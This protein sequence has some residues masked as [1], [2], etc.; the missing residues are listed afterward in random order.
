MTWDAV[1][2]QRSAERIRADVAPLADGWRSSHGRDVVLVHVQSDRPGGVGPSWYW[3]SKGHMWVSPEW[4]SYRREVRVRAARSLAVLDVVTGGA[5]LAQAARKEV[6]LEVVDRAR[7]IR[8]EVVKQ[9]RAK[10]RHVPEFSA[11]QEASP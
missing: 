3:T 10:G 9:L 7:Q 6:P 2:L 5:V 1:T 4:E 8:A 11:T